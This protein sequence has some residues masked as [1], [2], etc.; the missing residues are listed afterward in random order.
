MSVVLWLVSV[1]DRCL[2][3]IGVLIYL[4]GGLRMGPQSLQNLHS[5]CT[6]V[7]YYLLKV[8]VRGFDES[9]KSRGCEIVG[10][11]SGK[12]GCLWF[13]GKILSINL[14]EHT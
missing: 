8:K 3:N 1:L 13:P 12:S 6:T 7:P 10:W 11:V 4:F 9:C 2:L 14:S 5:T